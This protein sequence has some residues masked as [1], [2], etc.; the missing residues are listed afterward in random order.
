MDQRPT[1]LFDGVCN[2]CN[3]TVRFVIR[4]DRRRRFRFAPLQSDAARQL[5]GVTEP[6]AVALDSILLVEGSRVYR[7]SEAALRIARQLNH[8]W[9]L[10][11]VF[12]ILPRGVRDRVYDYIGNH[13]YRWFGRTESCQVPAPGDRD[14]FLD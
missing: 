12:S 14:R 1:I 7:K 6:G 4:R 5:L 3:A 9:P 2:L 13:R 11:A 10:L 8:P